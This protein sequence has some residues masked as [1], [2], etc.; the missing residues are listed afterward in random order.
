MMVINLMLLYRKGIIWFLQ[1]K[2]T[3][4][5]QVNDVIKW[6]TLM[7]FSFVI[8]KSRF[9]FRLKSAF[10]LMHSIGRIDFVLSFFN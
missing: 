2:T 3:A 8:K 5:F 1:D 9:Q 7:I 4:K 6:S 10:I